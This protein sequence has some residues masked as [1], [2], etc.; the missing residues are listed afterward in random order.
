MIVGASPGSVL[1]SDSDPT[2]KPKKCRYGKEYSMKTV[3]CDRIDLEELPS[4]HSDIEVYN[5]L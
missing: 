4:L 3:E 2:L 5:S 1:L